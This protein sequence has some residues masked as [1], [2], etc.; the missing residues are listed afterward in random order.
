MAL[1]GHAL[2][3]LLALGFHELTTTFLLGNHYS[4]LWH[5]RNGF[6]LLENPGS[7]RKMQRKIRAAWDED[8]ASDEC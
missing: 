3:R 5:W 1:L 6:E 2:N 4:M 8:E 7:L